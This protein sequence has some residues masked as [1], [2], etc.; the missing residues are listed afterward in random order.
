MPLRVYFRTDM[1]NSI[2]PLFQLHFL[3]YS[4]INSNL[5]LNHRHRK[6]TIIIIWQMIDSTRLHPCH[7]HTYFHSLAYRQVL[8]QCYRSCQCY[9]LFCYLQRERGKFKILVAE[10]F[11][12][13]SSILTKGPGYQKPKKR[14]LRNWCNSNYE[15]VIRITHRNSACVIGV[16]ARQNVIFIERCP[17]AP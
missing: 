2:A 12:Y 5:I 7:S 4:I 8:E 16:R 1:Q 6:S 15:I 17:S 3:Q 14:N 11:P 13:P 9:Y 10:N